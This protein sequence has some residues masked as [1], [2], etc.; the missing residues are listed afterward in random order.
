MKQLEGVMV[1][2]GGEEG[3]QPNR[4][5]GGEVERRRR[6]S[7]HDDLW[8]HIARDSRVCSDCSREDIWDKWDGDSDALGGLVI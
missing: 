5:R 8:K 4:G 3:Q 6:R 7:D 1:G 2:C